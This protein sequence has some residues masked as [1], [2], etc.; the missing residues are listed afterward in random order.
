MRIQSLV[1]DRNVKIIK[2]LFYKYARGMYR[3]NCHSFWLGGLK[4]PF[5]GDKV[6][7]VSVRMRHLP[8]SKGRPDCFRQKE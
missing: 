5:K 4:K 8:C 3:K 7:L 2:T 6:W 1:V